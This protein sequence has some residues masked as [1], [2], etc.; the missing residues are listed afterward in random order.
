MRQLKKMGVILL[1][2]LVLLQFVRPSRNRSKSKLPTDITNA[3]SIPAN[4]Q[5]IFS[6]ACSDCHSNNTHYPWYAQI[7][8]VGWL[9]ASHIRE[10]KAELNFSEFGA[11][12][13]RRQISK[14]SSI[15]NS[16]KDGTMP[17]DSYKWLH[18]GARLTE[19]EKMVIINWANDTKDSIQ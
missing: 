16:L 6:V 10:G 13:K 17:L 2:G 5:H 12:S 9:L 11:Y 7:Q 15:A 1:I 4:V 18:R 19:K 8:P 14:L 3:V